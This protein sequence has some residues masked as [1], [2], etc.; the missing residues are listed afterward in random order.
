MSKVALITGTSSGIGLSTAVLLA[1]SGFTTVATVREVDK[2]QALRERAQREGV[3]LDIQPLEV[4]DQASVDACIRGALVRHG[5]IDVLV[6]NA[7]VGHLGTIEQTPIEEAQRHFDVNFFGVY[8]VTQAVIP[9]MRAA[10]SGRIITV[11][12]INGVVGVPFNDV[13][14]A[15]KFAVE[16]LMEGLAPVM[17]RFGVRVSIIEPGPV[18]TEFLATREAHR[19]RQAPS[20]DDPYKPL[21][22]AYG[23]ALAGRMSVAQTGD[24]VAAVI[25]EAATAEAPHLRYQTSD[26]AR[27]I[28][29]R[30]RV[31][32]SGDAILKQTNA[33]IGE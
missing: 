22:E 20:G 14:N 32:P 26:F 13:Y 29:A 24:E 23:A 2:C 17:A 4:C 11:A 16:G 30:V 12:S 31:D 27:S 19:A 8:R 15:S 9:S 33:Q 1:R 21:L 18:K 10:R 6:N 5:R 25:L 28:A 3:D 7:G